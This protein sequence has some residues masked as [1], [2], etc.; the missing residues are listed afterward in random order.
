MMRQRTTASL[1]EYLKTRGLIEV[2]EVTDTITPR[3][4]LVDGQ[5]RV[6]PSW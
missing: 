1:Q 4:K 2:D 5:G 3:L 6:P